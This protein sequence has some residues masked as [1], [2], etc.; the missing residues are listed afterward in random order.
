MADPTADPAGSVPPE[1]RVHDALRTLVEE[2]L[3][4]IRDTAQQDLWT[5]DERARAEEDLE[6]VMAQVRREALSDR[7][8]E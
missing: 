1:R 2:M 7:Y 5:A 8:H 4:Q 3:M 6:R